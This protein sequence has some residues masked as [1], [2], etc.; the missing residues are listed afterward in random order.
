MRRMFFAPSC[1]GSRRLELGDAFR[2]GASE[3]AS[4]AG[5]SWT[6][7]LW[8]RQPCH[9]RFYLEYAGLQSTFRARRDAISGVS[10]LSLPP[11]NCIPA[12]HPRVIFY[13][14]IRQ[15]LS[16]YTSVLD[17]DR[18]L[19]FTMGVD[20][21]EEVV[22]DRLQAIVNTCTEVG[23]VEAWQGLIQEVYRNNLERYEPEELGDTPRSFGSQ[24][25]ENFKERCVRRFRRDERDRPDAHWYIQGLSVATPMNVLTF[26]FEDAHFVTMKVPYEQKRHPNWDGGVDW[27]QG[28][29]V[30][31]SLAAKNSE[32]LQYRT[33]AVGAVPLFAHPGSPGTVQNFMLL[34][35]GEANAALTAGW[36]AVPVLGDRPFIAHQKLWWDTDLDAQVTPTSM[37]DRGPNFDE[38]PAAALSMALKQQHQEGQ[39]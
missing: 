32:V 20:L 7:W 39:A 18:Q 34:W 23:L 27:T 1:I 12:R 4:P 28:S 6:Q 17:I 30:R 24:C 36:L 3:W 26:E 19:C 31:A 15:N 10:N 29:Q 8:P 9:T 35:G 22:Q 16:I 5:I 37:P 2:R 14:C 25:Y 21:V 33:P 11:R 13:F 38:R